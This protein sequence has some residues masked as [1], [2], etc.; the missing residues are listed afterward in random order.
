MGILVWL[1]VGAI[2]GFV[3]GKVVTGKGMGL[4]WDVVVGIAGAF[5]GGWLASLAGIGVST[6]T[7]TVG[8]VVAAIVGAIVLLGVFRLLTGRGM[9]HA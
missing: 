2:A 5:L 9:L 4:L 3:A 7:F 8:G 1:I 6:G